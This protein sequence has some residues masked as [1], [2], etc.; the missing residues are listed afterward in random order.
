MRKSI[1]KTNEYFLLLLLIVFVAIIGFINP[2]FFSI[3][4]LFDVIRN[5][6]IYILL[7]FALLPVVILGGFDISFAAIAAFATFPAILILTNLGYA[8]GIWLFY[9][10]AMIFGIA[11]GLI[12]AWL[13]WS[14]KLAIFDFSLGMS[15]VIF[16]LLA[17]FAGSRTTSGALPALTGWN[18]QWLVTVQSAVGESGLHVSFLLIILSF[19]ILNIFLRYTTAGRFIYALGSDK[20][21]AIRTGIDSKKIYMIVFSIMGALAAIAGATNS[22]LGFGNATFAGKFMRVYATVIIGGASIHGG[23]GSV[24][25][26]LLGVLLVGLINQAMIYLSIPTAWGDAFLGII[27]IVFTIFQIFETHFGKKRV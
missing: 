20:S 25:G 18:K 17:L 26:T 9:F 15:S 4:T 23:K 7:A 24:F 6:T 22:G 27:F 16:G 10:V 21:V 13:I 19:I 3:G 5:Q 11:A 12:N 14:F 1:H 8:G 2:A